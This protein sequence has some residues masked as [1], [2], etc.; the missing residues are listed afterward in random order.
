MKFLGFHRIVASLVM[1]FALVF[2]SQTAIAQDAAEAIATEQLESVDPAEAADV[3]DPGAVT[4]GSGAY[5]PMKPTEG[6]GMPVDAGL[7][8]QPQFSETGEF[9]YGLHIGLIWVMVAISLFVLVLMLYT[10]FRFRRSANP[11]PSKTSHNT[12]IEV[13][14]TVVPALILLAIAIPSI[15]LIAKQYEPIPKDAITIKATGY[16]W[17]WGYTYPDNGEF[18]IISNMLDDAEAEARGEP[19]QLAV[20]NR[21][22]VP[23]GVPI[24][25][26]ITAAD[27]IH[28]FAVP[29]LW[30]KLDAVPGRLNEKILMVEKPGVYYGQC[31][32]LCGARHAYMPIAV[33]AL[34]LEQYNQW[35]LAQGGTIAGAEETGDLD[36]ELAPLQEPE[37]TVEGAA[38]AGEFPVENPTT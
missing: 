31:S 10:I 5:T 14:W 12:L 25:M 16:Q 8:I 4:E 11:T 32:E 17:Y 30:F 19:H 38:G 23:V 28:S 2:G 15:T 7:D 20:D 9:A 6:I 36:A 27:V 24:R 18:E 22:V 26:Q 3:A 1:A 34:P 13:I 37:S 35:V 33:E 29:S 21:M